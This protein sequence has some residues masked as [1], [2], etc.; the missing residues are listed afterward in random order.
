MTQQKLVQ[1]QSECLEGVSNDP[2]AVAE[3]ML[4]LCRRMVIEQGVRALKQY[5]RQDACGADFGE[6]YSLMCRYHVLCVMRV[7]KVAEIVCLGCLLR[8]DVI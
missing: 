2:P 8:G 3:G 4:K 1:V 6:G 7:Q 5:E